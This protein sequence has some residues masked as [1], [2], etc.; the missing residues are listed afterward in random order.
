MLD[1]LQILIIPGCNHRNISMK[2]GITF[3]SILIFHIVQLSG[4]TE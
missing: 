1:Y 3:E 4:I 2:H